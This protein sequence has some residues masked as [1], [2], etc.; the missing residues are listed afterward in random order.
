MQN[1]QLKL[2]FTFN[3]LYL[4]FKT[5]KPHLIVDIYT[6]YSILQHTR[7]L[8]MNMFIIGLW[9]VALELLAY[10]DFQVPLTNSNSIFVLGFKLFQSFSIFF[11]ISTS[12]GGGLSHLLIKNG[13]GV[14][15]NISDIWL[16]VTWSSP[17]KK[18]HYKTKLERSSW[19][20]I[21][22]LIFVMFS[23]P[24]QVDLQSNDWHNT[25]DKTSL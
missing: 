20:N 18:E 8:V 25:N 9:Q 22:L 15:P 4:V 14:I 5:P 1:G 19:I 7:H 24:A 11:K 12:S 23:I 21:T 16:L 17:K 3:I 13:R 10:K 6:Q 2:S